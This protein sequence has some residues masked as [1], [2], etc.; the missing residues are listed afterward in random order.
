VAGGMINKTSPRAR[1][2]L[3]PVALLVLALAAP[4]AAAPAKQ[5]PAA[6]T[7]GPALMTNS[8]S[9]K[10]DLGPYTVDGCRNYTIKILRKMNVENIELGGGNTVFGA[11]PLNGRRYSIGIRCEVDNFLVSLVVAG[12]DQ[13]DAAAIMNRLDETWFGK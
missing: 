5:N 4:A 8:I 2:R 9:L 13:T 7:L 12:P 11:I 10:K 6:D 1:R 3:W